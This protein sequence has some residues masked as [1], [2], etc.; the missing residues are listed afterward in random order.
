VTGREGSQSISD[1]H[2]DRAGVTAKRFVAANWDPS[3]SPAEAAEKAG[4][5]IAWLG[6]ARMPIEPA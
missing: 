6:I 5:P 3:L 1:R 2:G 4:V